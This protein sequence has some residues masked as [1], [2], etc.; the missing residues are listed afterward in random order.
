[1]PLLAGPDADAAAER[2]QAAL[3]AS[4]RALAQGE[5][6]TYW[7][8]FLKVVGRSVGNVML[9]CLIAFAATMA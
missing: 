7:T 9:G 8:D 6:V 3:E 2:Q 5:S 1:M 4:A